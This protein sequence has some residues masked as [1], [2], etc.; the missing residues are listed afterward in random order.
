MKNQRLLFVLVTM[1]ASVAMFAQNWERPVAS[2]FKFTTEMKNSLQANE[3]YWKGDTTIY[4]LY[5]VEADAFLT[6]ATCRSHAQWSTHAALNATTGNKVMM[7]QWRQNPIIV[8]D[9]T[10]T[11]VEVVEADTSYTQT[12]MKVDTVSITIPEWDGVTYK[13]LDWYNG[14][15]RGVFPTSS[16]AM[17]VDRNGQADYMWNV[18]SMGGG[19]YRISVSDLNPEMNSHLADS[20]FGNPETYLGFNMIDPDYNADDDPPVMP[21]TPMLSITGKAYNPSPAEGFE[22]MEEAEL[23]IDWKFMPEEE[24]NKY[25]SY[26]RA[27]D[28]IANGELDTYI[29]GIEDRYGNKIDLKKLYDI[30]NSSQPV[31]YEDIQTAMAETEVAVREYLIATIFDGA[32][33]EN[34][35]DATVVLINPDLETGDITGWTV[36]YTKGTNVTNLGY[37]GASYTNGEVTISKFIEAWSNANYAND[38]A[39]KRT[40]GNGSVYQ[41]VTGLPA[42][43]YKFECDAIAT[44]QD[45][46]NKGLEKGA[47]L[48]ARGGDNIFRTE[49]HTDNNKPEHFEVTFINTGGDFE[50]GFMTDSTTVNWLCADNFQ[51]WFYGE[52]DPDDDPFRVILESTI[53]SLERQYPDVGDLMANNDVKDAFLEA[54]DHAKACQEGFEAENAALQAAAATLATSINDYKRMETLMSEVQAKAVAFEES[55]FPELSE[56][57]GEWYERNLMEAYNECTAD[58]A[59]IDSISIKMGAMIVE[60]I[61]AN[62]KPGDELTALISNPDYNNDFS[63]WENTGS[64][65]VFGGKGGNAPN[66]IGD[67]ES[68]NSGNAEVFQKAFDMFQIVRNMPKGAFR[69][70]AQAFE[71]NDNGWQDHFAEG[72]EVGISTVL[73]ANEFETKVHN[74][75]AFAQDS[76]IY[77]KADTESWP[78]D[79]Y[80][81]STDQWVPNSMDG[82]NFYFNLSPETYLVAVDFVLGHAGDSITIGLKTTA[83]NSWVIFDNFRLF[84][85][86]ESLEALEAPVNSMLAKLDALLAD[87]ESVYGADVMPN[88][89]SVRDEL[90]TAFAANDADGVFAALDKGTTALEYAVK[91]R[92]AYVALTAAY[93]VL[94][95]EYYAHEESEF[96]AETNTAVQEA[97]AKADDALVK[98]NLSPEEA[99]EL[100][101]QM[102]ELKSSLILPPAGYVDLTTEDFWLWT[103]PDETAEKVQQADGCVL[104]L[105]QNTGIVWGSG[106]GAV[107]YLNFA[108][109]TGA[110]ALIITASVGQPRCLFN[111]VVDEGTVQVEVPRDADYWTINENE[112]GSKTYIVDLKRINDEY[113]F[114]H[115]HSIKGASWQ[116]TNVSSIKVGWGID[117]S[118]S[119]LNVEN[120]AHTGIYTITGTRIS[121]LRR[122]INIIVDANGKARKVLV[123]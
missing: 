91:S 31:L 116:D 81:S 5:N 43:K 2:D 36:N 78:T 10:Y 56:I 103:A 23:A 33:E 41:L 115:L 32:T 59:M 26:C 53:A 27:W 50:F 1:F 24:Y 70:T 90:A 118:I 112:D 60:Y 99:T 6:N 114:V 113:G 40:L 15:Y 77:A 95:S 82:A 66:S 49:I 88:A 73:Y 120:K 57:L 51:L 38:P 79:T 47:Y 21:L 22:S 72:P 76:C 93:D 80:I 92:D 105:D 94:V 69:L 61:T 111:R 52:V 123:K 75:M 97:I 64:R 35:V 54:L 8:T 55:S 102:R 12:V 119:S 29:V 65:P 39:G 101:K 19:V 122:G 87:E 96:T 109:L 84:Y 17:F 63:G 4:Y 16:Y 45:E 106:S 100:A 98:F 7:A 71:R 86:G 67:I 104:Q 20:L 117:S 121:T 42:G 108:D 18:K 37:Q 85:T 74:I 44:R 48:Y 14:S 30:L 34:P 89:Q 110:E 107:Y 68:L 46:A 3:P 83:T 58:A 9:T 62:V 28:Y 13:L 25:S 11:E